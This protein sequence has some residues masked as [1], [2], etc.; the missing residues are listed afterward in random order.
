MLLTNYF[1]MISKNFYIKF[2]LHTCYLY[3]S[4]QYAP[5]QTALPADRYSRLVKHCLISLYQGFE[6]PWISHILDHCSF[7]AGVKREI[8][9][10]VLAAL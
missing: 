2:P 1:I 6:V 3:N 10:L 7:V 9:V 5:D 8:A 4:N